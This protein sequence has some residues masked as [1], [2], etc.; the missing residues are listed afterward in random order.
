MVPALCLVL[1][2]CGCGLGQYK[3]TVRGSEVL[4]QRSL[5]LTENAKGYAL[6]VQGLSL[7]D[8]AELTLV[9]DESLESA[10]VLE[11]D[12][13]ILHRL[14]LERGPAPDEIT[15][16]APYY[17]NFA[18]SKLALTVG[19][20]V[21][22]LAVE[23]MWNI[24]YDCPSV[25][26]FRFVAEGDI[27]SDFT[28]GELD[29]LDMGLS[30]FS[31]INMSSPGI[32]DCRINADGD[33]GGDYAIGESKNLHVNLSGFGR[34]NISG[35]AERA[36]FVLEGDADITALGL[37]AQEADVNI[38]GM[39][40]CEITAEQRLNVVIEGAGSVLYGGSPTVSQTI[41]GFGSIKAKD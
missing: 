33:C 26:T 13:N 20:P 21:R 36:V 11:T 4:R 6:R 12:S 7:R 17:L 8:V 37:T 14:R 35:A 16:S 40:S 39:G 31:Q 24:C 2:L 10:V 1:T 27:R 23:G 38:D 34:I 19:A 41:E 3:E 28:F 18:P 22:E 32:T 5:P 30:G 29:R 9:I 25:K 15:L